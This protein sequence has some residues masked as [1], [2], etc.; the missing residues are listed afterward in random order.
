MIRAW[1][2]GPQ[3]PMNV[4]YSNG[5]PTM[6][7]KIM[8]QQRDADADLIDEAIE[9]AENLRENG[10]DAAPPEQIADV[11]DELWTTVSMRS[12]EIDRLQRK[13]HDA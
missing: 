4:S 13:T 10:Y 8:G 3:Q 6:R 2:W 9:L 11:L 12:R 7:R 5:R 1:D